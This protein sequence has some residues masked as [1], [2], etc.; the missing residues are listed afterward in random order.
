MSLKLKIDENEQI[1]IRNGKPVYLDD[2]NKEIELD[3]NLLFDKIKDLNGEAKQRRLE[4]QALK[5]KYNIFNDIDNISEWKESA[6]K[7]IKL[8]KDID[9]SQLIQVGKVDEVKANMKLAHD[10]EKNN[11][12]KAFEDETK[13]LNALLEAKDETIFTLMVTS[14][15]SQSSLFSGEKPKTILPPEIAAKYFGHQ[16]KVEKN[17]DG[18]LRVIGFHLNGSQIYSRKNPGELADFEEAIT[19]IIDEYPMKDSIM[20]AGFDG[21]GSAGGD[22]SGGG[23]KLSA[24]KEKYNEALKKADTQL[25]ISLKNQIFVLEKQ[26]L[27][28]RI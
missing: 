21:S 7:A 1:E 3:A 18:N 6:D 8:S 16:F 10:E 27:G 25:A 14:K 15:F 28:K 5:D 20:R 12:K 22:H 23:D 26:K 11:M 19:E 2:E 13:T 4:C 24:L 17:D 9:D